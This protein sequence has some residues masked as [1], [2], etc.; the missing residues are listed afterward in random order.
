MIL[1]S[2]VL[3]SLLRLSLGSATCA[4]KR[5]TSP[6]VQLDRATVVGTVNGSVESFLGIPYAQPPVGDLRLRLPQ[7]LD[8]YNGT[9][10]ATALGNQCI[11]QALTL[12]PNVPPDA[13]QGA[14]PLFVLFSPNPDVTQSE[15]CLN[16]NVIRPANISPHAKLPVL[17]WIYGGAYADGSNAMPGYNGT[18]V[19]ERSIEIGEPV[20]FV[21][22]NYRLHVFGFLGGKEVQQ[23]GIANLGLHD[24]RAALRWTNHFIS[25]FG[26]DP[27]KVTIWGES[28]GAFS[29]FLHLFT[30]GGNTE[31]LFRAGIM[32]SGSSVPTGKIAEIQGTYDFVVDQVGC[33]NA[34]DT[35]VCLR[36]VPTDSLLA[37]ANNTPPVTGFTGLAT[38]YMPRADGVFIAEPPQ[39]LALHGKI[40]DV[41]IIIGDVQDEGTIFSLGSL[42]ITT[43]AQFASYLAQAWFPGATPADLSKVLKLY[44]SDPAS[45]SPFGT[46]SANALTPEYKRIAA[47]QGD[48]FFNARRR[49][50]LDRFSRQQTMYNFLSARGNFTGVGDAHG[51]DLFTAFGPGDMT[52]YFVR[53][54]NH[55]N[56]NGGNGT[57]LVW[58]RYN[59]RTRLAL[60]FKDGSTPLEVA[61]DD[62]RLEGTNELLSLSLRFPL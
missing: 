9:I 15:D 23:A 31:G 33:A 61:A 42:N 50:L 12:P 34:T 55:L 40:A 24:Q 14:L 32:N 36:T 27:T 59:P 8:S 10:D 5:Q 21:A 45:G 56:P 35:L 57:E 29:V 7:L 52:D 17:F 3:L 47:V 6:T 2:A 28:A 58:P 43:D 13:L 18:A 41:P 22:L 1:L 25:S 20:I 26:G 44:P 54:V 30:N 38:P 62:D 46:G 51:S 48:W 16:I 19:V 60:Q 4:T 37:A 11:Q 49:Q 53:F 39:Q